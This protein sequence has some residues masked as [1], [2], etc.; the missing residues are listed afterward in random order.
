[1]VSDSAIEGVERAEYGNAFRLRAAMSAAL[2]GRDTGPGRDVTL[3][4]TSAGSQEQT[5]KKAIERGGPGFPGPSAGG[6]LTHAVTMWLTSKLSASASKR[7][8]PT[9]YLSQVWRS[10]GLSVSLTSRTSLRKSFNTQVSGKSATP[11]SSK[12]REQV[13]SFYAFG[14]LRLVYHKSIRSNSFPGNLS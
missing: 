3:D 12:N 9:R 10:C 11:C 1:M 4:P 14:S 13:A 8:K 5:F 6:H 7:G 2:S